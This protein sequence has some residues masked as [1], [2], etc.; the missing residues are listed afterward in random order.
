MYT[1][2]KLNENEI[3]LNFRYMYAIFMIHIILSMIH[4]V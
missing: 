3:S 2:G 1:I 4:T